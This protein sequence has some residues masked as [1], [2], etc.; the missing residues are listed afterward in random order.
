MSSARRTCHHRDAT[1]GAASSVQCLAWL[2]GPIPCASHSA[3]AL[4]AELIAIFHS[5]VGTISAPVPITLSWGGRLMTAL[6]MYA[7]TSYPSRL[8]FIIDS[9]LRN[10]T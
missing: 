7:P 9:G 6:E 2:V 3:R 4:S 8:R 5:E 1:Q 10:R